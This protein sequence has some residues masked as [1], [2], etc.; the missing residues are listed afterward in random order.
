MSAS[1]SQR[2]VLQRIEEGLEASKARVET[3]PVIIERNIVRVDVMI[4]PFDF[5]D[6]LIRENHWDYLYH[7]SDIV[8]PR[9]VQDFYGYLEVVQDE[10][11]GL[12]LQTT[13]RGVT[14]KVDAAL[15]VSFIG[16]N[17]VPFEGIPFPDFVD[18]P[19]WKNCACFL[20]LCIELQI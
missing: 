19:P 4:P 17:P 9:L 14:F 7:Y 6:R 13:V 20:I 5:I 8:Y 1:S 12:T 2:R 10:Q 11:S 3:K 18:P 16:T 15:I